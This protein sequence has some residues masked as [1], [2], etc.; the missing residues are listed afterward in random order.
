MVLLVGSAGVI[1][2]SRASA[3]YNAEKY[4][5]RQLGSST[6]NNPGDSPGDAGTVG[7]VRLR[8]T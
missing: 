8:T 7:I 3:D 5:T 2:V 6:G 4:S 1:R